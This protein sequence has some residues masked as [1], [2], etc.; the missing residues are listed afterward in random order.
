MAENWYIFK[1]GLQTGP[2]SLSILEQMVRTREL[3]ETDLVISDQMKEWVSADTVS[4]LFSATVYAPPPP[5]SM[6]INVAAPPPPSAFPSVSSTVASPP[7]QFAPPPPTAAGSKTLNAPPP[8]VGGSVNSA[9]IFQPNIG[10]RPAPNN[11]N[12]RMAVKPG[13][14][15]WK[16]PIIIGSVVILLFLV[17][18]VIA[19]LADEPTPAPDAAQIGTQPSGETV[20]AGTGS[21]GEQSQATTQQGVNVFNEPGYGFT[22]N[23]PQGWNYRIDADGT[24][25]FQGAQGSDDFYNIFMVIVIPTSRNGGNYSSLNDVLSGLRKLYDSLDG[26]I[27]AVEEV[28]AQIGNLTHRVLQVIANYDSSEGSIIEV[29]FIIERDS[30]YYYQLL[31]SAPEEISEAYIDMIMSDVVNTFNFTDF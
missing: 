24:I 13:R 23:Y 2:F 10:S 21:Q 16:T 22:M 12:H 9:P 20:P 5:V 26:E 30:N 15:K 19:A 7:A 17:V 8:P 6:P 31:Y 28:E 11:G 25:I 29:Q 14:Q 18:I 1:N 3:A 27:L 4:G